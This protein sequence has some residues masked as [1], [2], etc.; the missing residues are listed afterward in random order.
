MAKCFIFLCIFGDLDRVETGVSEEGINS[1]K[2]LPKSN[3]LLW[4]VK[5]LIIKRQNSI[6][7]FLIYFLNKSISIIKIGTGTLCLPFADPL[8]ETGN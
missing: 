3:K 4:R 1:L 6:L 2:A 7:K 8:C 5:T